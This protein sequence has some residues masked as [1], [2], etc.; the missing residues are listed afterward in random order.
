MYN[1]TKSVTQIQ[2]VGLFTA[3]FL[4]SFVPPSTIKKQTQ[5]LHDLDTLMVEHMLKHLLD[6]LA[7]LCHSTGA[8]Q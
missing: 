6:T 3:S 5:N 1:F 7:H 2:F 8:T 4:N